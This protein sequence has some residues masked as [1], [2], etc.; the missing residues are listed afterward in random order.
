MGRLKNRVIICAVLLANLTLHGGCRQQRSY[1]Y[2]EDENS[3]TVKLRNELISLSNGKTKEITG[4]T[5]SDEG[6]VLMYGY[7]LTE[8]L[9]QLP[10]PS[11]L[12]AKLEDIRPPRDYEVY[13]LAHFRGNDIVEYTK[14]RDDG[15]WPVHS[16]RNV[17][18]L[19]RGNPYKGA[20]K[21]LYGDVEISS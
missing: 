1:N 8:S 10:I 12:H 19:I 21:N 17:P 5:Q 14:W 18:L 11:T 16:I 9:Y 2:T 15:S 13:V 4:S 7:M 20:R 6:Y 3:K